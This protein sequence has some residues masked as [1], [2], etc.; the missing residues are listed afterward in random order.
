MS[1]LS[2]I[3]R[4][5]N[6]QKAYTGSLSNLAFLFYL[7]DY[8]SS[9]V[10]H[11]ASFFDYFAYGFYKTRNKY[12]KEYITYRRH[13]KIQRIC[14]PDRKEIEICRD[15]RAFNNRFSLYIQRGWLDVDKSSYDQFY[16]FINKSKG[17]IFIKGADGFCGNDVR[18][19]IKENIN[20][21]RLYKELKSKGNYILEEGINQSKEL[22]E[23]NFSSV[24]TIRITTIYNPDL[25]EVIIMKANI[26][27]GRKNSDI[28]NLHAGGLAAH[29]DTDSGIIYSPAYDKNNNFFIHHPD[30]NKQI[31]GYKIPYWEECKEF[32][33]EVAKQLPKVRYVGWDIVGLE[34]G[35]FCLI[36]ANDNADH[37][38]Q[39]LNGKGLWK[40]YRTI[41]NTLKLIK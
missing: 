7:A 40:E 4:F 15:K 23:F 13:K 24:N 11:G 16:E 12:K 8:F 6:L 10:I 9:F 35:R 36:E 26:R 1:P 32:I 28:D 41:L 39:Q 37:D 20:P 31:V 33:S 5:R 19:I 3:K 27:L 22:S 25:E 29:I 30:S 18:S 21:N 2:Y 17:K 38:I 34:N 14:N